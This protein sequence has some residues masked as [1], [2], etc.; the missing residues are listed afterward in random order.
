MALKDVLTS[1]T[2]KIVVGGVAVVA[3]AYAL[4][5]SLSK[6]GRPIARAALKSGVILYEKARETVA[7]MGEVLEDLVAETRAELENR[8][9]TETPVVAEAV[10]DTAQGVAIEIK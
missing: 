3:V 2:T 1:D 8:G 6:I 10:K 5:P 9:V 7:E 4:I